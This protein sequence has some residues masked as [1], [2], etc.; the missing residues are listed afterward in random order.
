[1]IQF[2]YCC[3]NM[4]LQEQFGI[5]TNRTMRKKTFQEKGLAHV[6]NLSM[7]N[8]ADLIKLIEWNNENGIKIFRI[9]SEMFPWA[10]E[11]KWEQLPDFNK[12]LDN[13]QAAGDAAKRGN[14]RLTFH[15]GPFNCL[16]SS[17]DQIVK[18]CVRDL[19]IHSDIMDMLGQPRDH[20][21][22]IN[23]HLGGSYGDKESA[24]KNWCRN[25]ENLPEGIKSRLT[26]ENDDRQN[27]YSTKMLYDL[28]HHQV[29]VPIVFDSHHYE[30]GPQDSSYEEAFEM[31]F[32]SWPAHIR[33]IFHHS[34]SKKEYEDPAALVNAHSDYYYKPF[35]SLGKNVDVDLE[36]KSKEKGLFDYIKKFNAAS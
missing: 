16:T 36:C 5:G 2:G 30:C 18:N 29:G 13:M 6:S 24:A 20:R 4:T 3:I 14:Q 25:Y 17:N 19:Q 34:N 26:V 21:A 1:M 11:Y 22:V 7:Q 27:L 28:V 15:P 35:I 9:S 23:I 31:S 10:S 8:T 33:P 32:S 12:I